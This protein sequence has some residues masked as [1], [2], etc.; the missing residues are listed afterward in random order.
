MTRAE[1]DTPSPGAGGGAGPRALGAEPGPGAQEAEPVPGA[2]GPF[3]SGSTKNSPDT[4]AHGWACWS[5]R[6]SVGHSVHLPLLP[7]LAYLLSGGKLFVP[8]AVTRLH[9]PPPASGMTQD[10]PGLLPP[11]PLGRCPQSTCADR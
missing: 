8:T 11:A 5:L 9:T 1:E 3:G 7:R 10:L 6:P 4:H 2:L